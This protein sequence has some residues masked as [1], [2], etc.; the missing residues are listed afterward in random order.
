MAALPKRDDGR[1]SP[2]EQVAIALATKLRTADVAE[3]NEATL[4]EVESAL[5]RLSDVIAS[6]YYTTQMRSEAQHEAHG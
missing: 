4:L 2:P 6:T 1:L 3:I 5:M